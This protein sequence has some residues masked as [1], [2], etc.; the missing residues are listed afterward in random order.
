MPDSMYACNT[1]ARPPHTLACD[2]AFSVDIDILDISTAGTWQSLIRDCTCQLHRSVHKPAKAEVQGLPSMLAGSWRA[3]CGMHTR[4]PHIA[5]VYKWSQLFLVLSSS[6]PS[7]L[8]QKLHRVKALHSDEATV[9]N[10]TACSLLW[11]S[12]LMASLHDSPGAPKLIT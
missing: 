10:A 9:D 8:T 2:S 12:F 1:R 3:G 4:T 11:P 7:Q 6:A 5:L